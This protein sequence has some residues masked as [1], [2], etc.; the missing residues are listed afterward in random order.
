M[1]H[2]EYTCVLCG[3]G[4]CWYL[5]CKGCGK[6]IAGGA[7]VVNITP[8][9]FTPT[10][11]SAMT[12]IHRIQIYPVDSAIGHFRVPPGLCI[13]TRLGAQLFLWK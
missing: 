13:K 3:E 8:R 11:D 9:L 6:T 2:T 7:S 4:M 12:A 1:E 5:A 10:L